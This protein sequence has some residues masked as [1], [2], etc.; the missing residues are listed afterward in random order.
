MSKTEH[1][2]LE[3]E[4]RETPQLRTA[5]KVHARL[6]SRS[7][8]RRRA[9]ELDIIDYY[10]L[11]V[12]T[13]RRSAV[14]EYVLD[15]RFIDPSLRESRHIAWRWMITTLAFAMLAAASVWRI[16]SSLPP[17]WQQGQLPICA[18]MLGLTACAG[19]VCVYRTTETLSLHSVHGQVRLL[20]LTGGPGTV[21]AT[22][23]FMLK[24]AAHIRIAIAARRPLRARHLRDEMREHFRL[25][26][27]GV[28]S[29]EEYEESKRRILA[30][31]AAG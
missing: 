3:S 31:H 6:R 10:Y 2:L 8:L 17:W 11:S 24:L 20:E 30:E 26:E 13:R 4:D 12:R 18:T 9:L 22:R 28:L 27:A 29:H 21:R 5:R 23:P 7:R 1:I 16:G 14:L 19:L 15:L 25:K